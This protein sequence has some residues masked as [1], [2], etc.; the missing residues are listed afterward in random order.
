MVCLLWIVTHCL[1]VIYCWQ[2]NFINECSVFIGGV[3]IVG[4]AYCWWFTFI[5][6]GCYLLIIILGRVAFYLRW[7]SII[8]FILILIPYYIWYLDV[9]L[10]CD[11]GIGMSVLLILIISSSWVVCVTLDIVL[12]IRIPCLGFLDNLIIC[13]WIIHYLSCTVGVGAWLGDH[14]IGR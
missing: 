9:D 13:V 8:Y 4:R 11:F 14:T 12:A 7:I 3:F 1:D 2:L 6:D 5:D 10:V